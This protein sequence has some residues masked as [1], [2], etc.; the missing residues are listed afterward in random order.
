MRAPFAEETRRP[1]KLMNDTGFRHRVPRIRNDPEIALQPRLMQAHGGAHRRHHVIAAMD[2]DPWNALQPMRLEQKRAVAGK[3]CSVHE[4]MA[5]DP[6]ESQ[7]VGICAESADAVRL[8][9]ERQRRPFP[10]AP[11]SGSHD[12][13]LG[14]I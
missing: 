10:Y 11:G 5:F 1:D 6:R 14:V 3:E 7:R 12:P 4:V 9:D 2:D 8:G 13:R